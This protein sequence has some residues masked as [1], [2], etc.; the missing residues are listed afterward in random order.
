M[1]ILCK[2]TQQTDRTLVQN[3]ETKKQSQ[4]TLTA[5]EILCGEE[6][7]KQD[8]SR[9]RI[10]LAIQEHQTPSEV[11]P[12]IQ[13]GFNSLRSQKWYK[14]DENSNQNPS[15]TTM[16]IAYNIT[17]GNTAHWSPQLI[18]K[19]WPEAT[20]VWT[21]YIKSNVFAVYKYKIEQEIWITRVKSQV[22]SLLLIFIEME[23]LS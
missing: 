16:G 14:V 11:K 1:D 3:V 22:A 15:V 21:R 9:C 19:W 4:Q 20:T 5:R 2:F 6:K 18:A 8:V 17:R 23:F 10:P 12:Q 7:T 13:Y